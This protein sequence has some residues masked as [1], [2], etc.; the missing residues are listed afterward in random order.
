MV[1]L[2]ADEV[3]EVRTALELRKR[4]SGVGTGPHETCKRVLQK[5]A[6]SERNTAPST[7]GKSKEARRE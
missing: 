1:M 3:Q 7:N 4:T 6:E 2:E 5:L